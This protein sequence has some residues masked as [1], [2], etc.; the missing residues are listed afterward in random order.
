MA[1]D[2]GRPPDGGAEPAGAQPQ[3]HAMLEQAGDVHGDAPGGVA[4]KRGL[5]TC[6]FVSWHDVHTSPL[7]L[8]LREHDERT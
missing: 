2:L 8:S 5:G 7:N 1:S 6:A 3:L 4:H